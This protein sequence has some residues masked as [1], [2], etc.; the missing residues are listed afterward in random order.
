M[1]SDDRAFLFTCETPSNGYALNFYW[2]LFIDLYFGIG[3][4]NKRIMS[5]MLKMLEDEDRLVREAACISL[6]HMQSEVAV[7]YLV[8]VW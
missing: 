8:E 5:R 4:K 3:I 6:G 7:P 1:T 2:H